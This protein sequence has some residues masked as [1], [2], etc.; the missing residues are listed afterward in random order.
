MKGFSDP[1]RFPLPALVLAA[2]CALYLVVGTLGHDPWKS[3]DALHL[4][5]A[6]GFFAGD[7]WLVPRIAG[8]AWSGVAPLYHWV[9]AIL[10]WVTQ[11]ALPFH[12]GARLASV[13]FGATF[14]F[15]LFR[16]AVS[17]YG[18]E[19]GLAAPALTI[20]A[21]GLLVPVHD[22]QPAI[23]VL[24]AAAVAY[25]GLA[26]M[27][28]K[29]LPS[30]AVLGIGVGIAIAADGVSGAAP[31]LPLLLLPLVQRRWIAFFIALYVA[32]A[33]ASLWP[34]LL[35][36]RTPGHL[37]AWWGDELRTL[38][39]HR[40]AFGRD[41]FELLGWFAWPVLPIALWAA[42]IGR[43]Q[44]RAWNLLVPIGGALAALIWFL[45]HEPRPLVALP[46]LPPLVLLACSGVH[47]LRRG[48]S[49]A[50]DW[51]GMMTFS[52]AIAL[53]WLGGIAMWTGWP[54]QIAHNFAK[55]EPGYEP[56][57]SLPALIVALGFT[58]AW[59]A[60][61]LRLRR[62]PWRTAIRWAAG[63]TAMWGV[64]VALWMPWIDYGKTY[65][66]V[67]NSLRASLPEDAGCVERRGVG[68]PQRA[69]LDYLAGIRTVPESRMADCG[70]MLVQGTRKEPRLQ[71][72]N[73]VWEGHRP[74]DK[75]E[76]LRLYKRD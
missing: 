2:A 50:L 66:S 61:I 32:I 8:D 71:G 1:P 36:L 5:V 60:A 73:K 75:T 7:G 54:A 28:E 76:R 30:A 16:A 48:A 19:A 4:G 6:W 33:I 35:A 42:W 52:L 51:F 11:W 38:A 29:P 34:T 44:W 18:R 27:P 49:N 67:A 21:V 74:G 70:W 59:I 23:A 55:L 69:M 72:W 10:A 64:L 39:V 26:R 63:M 40:H 43:L 20:G 46:L 41:H 24:A 65:R 22:A 37:L 53:I 14:I 56:R 57:F 12:E 58:A 13:A 9:A 62:S 3:D 25:L 45:A 17:L 68:L 31:L 15:L 47:R